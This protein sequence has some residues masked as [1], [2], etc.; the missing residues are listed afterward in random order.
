MSGD[1]TIVQSEAMVMRQVAQLEGEK[2]GEES[3]T[4]PVQGQFSLE[5]KSCERNARQ[6]V[7][8]W[9]EN[10]DARTRAIEAKAGEKNRCADLKIKSALCV[11]LLCFVWIVLLK[12]G[13]SEGEEL[14]LSGRRGASELLPS[15][16]LIEGDQERAVEIG[17]VTVL[18]GGGEKHPEQDMGQGTEEIARQAA[19]SFFLGECD[20]SVRLYQQLQREEPEELKWNQ[21]T[22]LVDRSCAKGRSHL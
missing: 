10:G 3:G 1:E 13:E 21:L 7:K 6:Q 19:R 4:A 15:S 2:Q 18:S 9:G 20:K 12:T 17:E 8:Q 14:N 16:L 5:G 22:R 11:S